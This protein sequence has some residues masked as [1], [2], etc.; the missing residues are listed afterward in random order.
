VILSVRNTLFGLTTAHGIV[1][2]RSET[3]VLFPMDAAE[4]T[5][6]NLSASDSDSETGSLLSSEASF[7]E[8]CPS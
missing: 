1:S 7:E 3:S 4:S 6:G 2:C 8:D 5:E